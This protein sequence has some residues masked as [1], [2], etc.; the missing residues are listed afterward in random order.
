M[1]VNTVTTVIAIAI[2][3]LIA[4]GFYAFWGGEKAS[5][6]HYATTGSALIFSLVTLCGAIGINFETSRIT[7]V[8]RAVAGVSFF[9]G[10]GVLILITNLTDN[11]PILII[12]MGVLSS[13]FVLVTYA[14]SRSGQ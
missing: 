10:L 7:T 5:D 12:V 8:N 11:M 4:Y 13:L 6:L 2:S 1:K 14:I 3:G 9:I